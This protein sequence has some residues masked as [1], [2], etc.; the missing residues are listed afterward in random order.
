MTGQ[1][2]AIDGGAESISGT[3]RFF[4]FRLCFVASLGGL[5]FGFDTAVISGT[6]SFVEKQFG[7]SK[8]EVGW[9]ASS[10]LLGC[11]I[12]TMIAGALAD[13]F[14]RKPVLIAAAA[15]F[16][17]SAL[18]STIPPD[19]GV[20]IPARIIGGFG[21]G[22]ASVLSPL[23]ISEFSPAERRGRLGALYQLSIVIGILAAYFSNWCLLRFAQSPSPVFAA[24]GWPHRIFVSEVWRAMFGAEMIPAAL[25]FLLLFNVPESPRWLI[26]A[27]RTGKGFHL[28]SRVSGR[29]KAAAET[30][31][32]EASLGRETGRLRDLF[33]P[34]L[35]TAL[36]VG[37]GLSFFGQLT[38]VNIVIYYGP[39]ILAEAGFPLGNALQFQVGFGIV[40]FVFTLIAIW[41][42]DRWG[43]RPLLLG[44]MA[45]VVAALAA[46]AILFPFS[47]ATSLAIAAVLAVYVAC[48]AISI[49]AVIWVLTPEIFPTRIRAR[50][51]S[52]SA[53]TNWA[54]NGASALLFPWYVSRMG[55]ASGFW[56]FAGI[57]L[58]ATIFFWR[59]VPE[60]K[61]RSL[62][63][64]E[65]F[66]LQPGISRQPEKAAAGQG[67]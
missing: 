48:I 13:R 7:L 12:G 66:W 45:A 20:L 39:T 38:G 51:M 10:A 9:F 52:I 4:L 23:Y 60:T 30:K 8:L 47:P 43:R 34:G 57:C 58:V 28:L 21:V 65:A 50:A 24:G 14:G 26:K 55:M 17:I 1:E 33:R 5:L 49:C 19:F 25:F 41:K 62:E 16:F 35:R 29:E 59:L 64:I 32:I 36:L 22:I 46:A 40:N 67:G 54:T 37:C 53:F 31:E 42:I 44:G 18:Y 6:F 61:G 56:T 2:S 27:G 15:F 3:R 63:E 11:I